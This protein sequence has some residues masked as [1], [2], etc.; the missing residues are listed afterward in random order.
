MVHLCHHRWGFLFNRLFIAVFRPVRF[1]V[2]FFPSIA[3][4]AAPD[5]YPVS[6]GGAGILA[7][8]FDLWFQLGLT[9][10]FPIHQHI[11]D[12]DR[13]HHRVLRSVIFDHYGQR[14]HCAVDQ[15]S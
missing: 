11:F 15:E 8:T 4:L 13:R 1:G 12:P 5:G 9:G 3:D 10:A 6:V 2:S 14:A 7:R